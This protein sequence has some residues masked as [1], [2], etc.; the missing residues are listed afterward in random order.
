VTPDA[1]VTDALELMR[2]RALRR[3]IVVENGK[4][5]GMLSIGDVAVGGD[6]ESALG[7]ISGAVPNR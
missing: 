1:R 7:R 6:P 2:E 4:P 5:V 3:L